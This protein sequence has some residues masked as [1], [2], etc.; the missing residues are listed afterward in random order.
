MASALT[1]ALLALWLFSMP[2]FAQSGAGGI[3]GAFGK[4][5]APEFGAISL[6][7]RRIIDA[8]TE[9]RAF[10][11]L[12]LARVDSRRQGLNFLRSLKGGL[13]DSLLADLT[14]L[15]APGP[16]R[17]RPLPLKTTADLEALDDYGGVAFLLGRN[18][19]D[20]KDPQV[21]EELNAR[22][23]EFNA[24]IQTKLLG[25]TG[26][27]FELKIASLNALIATLEESAAV[28][29]KLTE[30]PEFAELKIHLSRATELFV[31]SEEEGVIF[32]GSA[33]GELQ[34]AQKL[35]R[36]VKRRWKTFFRRNEAGLASDLQALNTLRSAIAMEIAE[37]DATI[38]L[39]EDV[40][41]ENES[42]RGVIAS[43]FSAG[44]RH[45][46]PR[47]EKYMPTDFRPGDPVEVVQ[48][49]EGKI[50]GRI[51]GIFYRSRENE[52]AIAVNSNGTIQ[53]RE[54]NNPFRSGSFELEL[55]PDLRLERRQTLM[56]YAALGAAGAVAAYLYFW[57]A[58]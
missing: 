9:H 26:A 49:V 51:H 13:A 15:L 23:T 55:R 58:D 3:P 42:R 12:E 50:T 33:I 21:L 32:R 24:K 57:S 17:I 30:L 5:C 27:A 25:D 37:T 46:K 44:N 47:G 38:R 48:R 16:P 10:L 54:Y 34:E 43:L 19:F 35:L 14:D 2:A 40:A 45:R 53:V 41:I 4:G 7:P 56:R 1:V 36:R 18:D 28:W 8:E 39:A 31:R 22:I 20:P 52:F 6:N 11:M 29:P